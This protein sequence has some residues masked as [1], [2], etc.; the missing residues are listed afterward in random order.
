V[1]QE[2][3]V[4]DTIVLVKCECVGEN[5]YWVDC[6]K[7]GHDESCYASMCLHCGEYEYVDC[8]TDDRRM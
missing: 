4:P 6:P 2:V 7:Q 1:R 8:E 3:L 5:A